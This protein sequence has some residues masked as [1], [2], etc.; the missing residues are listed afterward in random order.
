MRPAPS[1]GPAIV[2]GARNLGAVITRDLLASGA[3]VVTIA[4][5]RADLARLEADGAVAIEADAADP[6]A[7][8]DAFARIAAELGPPDLIVNAVSAASPPADGSGFGGGPVAA[9][10]LAGFDGW[11]TPVARQ[12]FVFLGA[13][14]R[15]VTRGGT[16]VQITGAPARRANPG[17]GLLA[18][19]GAATLAHAAA[20]ELR[21]DG[22]HVAVLIVDGMIASPKTAAMTRAMPP[23]ALVRGDDVARAVLALSGQS[24][25]GWTP[26]IVLTPAGG[27]WV[28]G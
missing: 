27:T 14:A 15:A 17:R 7:L 28:P 22:I 6:G 25:G 5:T 24:P 9:A 12:A 19:G 21:G 10:T 26:E 8:G 1:P 4:R 16:L 2:L 23:D 18:A 11:V 3:P 20:Q 13:G